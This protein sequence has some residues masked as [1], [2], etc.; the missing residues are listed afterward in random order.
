MNIKSDQNGYF[1]NF[2]KIF[3]EKLYD[4]NGKNKLTLSSY[5]GDIFISSFK[6]STQYE[7]KDPHGN[8]IFKL[9]DISLRE[10]KKGY[11][12]MYKTRENDYALYNFTKDC[13]E[14][15]VILYCD[16]DEIQDEITVFDYISEIFNIF[17]RREQLTKK[18]IF[19]YE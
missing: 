7:G 15:D 16:S 1:H 19:T 8:D 18:I 10:Y 11:C 3:S 2:K 13:I 5:I 9:F 12:D 14:F 17:P 4:L 6:F